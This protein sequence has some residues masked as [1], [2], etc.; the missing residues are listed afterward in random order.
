MQDR[1]RPVL[2][3][4]DQTNLLAQA[5]GCQL[6]IEGL[7]VFRPKGNDQRVDLRTEIESAQ[8]MNDERYSRDLGKLFR[9]L[10]AE[11]N[12]LPGSGDNS[13]VHKQCLERAKYIIYYILYILL[14][15]YYYSM[16]DEGAG[17]GVGRDGRSRTSR[18]SRT[19]ALVSSTRPKI[20]LPA[21]VCRTLVTTI[22]T[23]FPI[24]RRA[25][26]TTTIVPSSR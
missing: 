10:S 7:D 4:I 11:T 19:S 25:L 2:A 22:S 1:S 23:F 16:I 15:H 6:S 13:N 17:I 8:C 14:A 3:S 9:P 5:G 20:I 21:V 12:A 18:C 26:S 24:S